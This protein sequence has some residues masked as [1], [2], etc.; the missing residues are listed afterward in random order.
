MGS[1]ECDL[2]ILDDA[3]VRGQLEQK[4][5]CRSMGCKGHLLLNTDNYFAI[6]MLCMCVVNV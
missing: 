4:V 6:Q 1:L 5:G 3:S 2:A